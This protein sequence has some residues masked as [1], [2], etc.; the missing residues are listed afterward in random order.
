VLEA[1][2]E[3][4]E[5]LRSRLRKKIPRSVTTLVVYGSVARREDTPESDLDLLVLVS[6]VRDKEAVQPWI[7][8]IF[9]ALSE[10]FGVRLSPLVLTGAEFFSRFRRHDSFIGNLM[11]NAELLHG[12]PLEGV[13]GAAEK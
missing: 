13:V 7:D 10:E 5:G 12:T 2:A 8:E 1:E 11:E 3:F 9:R 6:A 4:R